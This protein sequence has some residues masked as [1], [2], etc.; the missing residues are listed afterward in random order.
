MGTKITI[1][2][3]QEKNWGEI[4]ITK[5]ETC[6]EEMEN[7]INDN[8]IGIGYREDS[9][10]VDSKND[11]KMNIYNC[12]PYD[13]GVIWGNVEIKYCPFCGKKIKIYIVEMK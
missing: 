3:K 10:M 6:C 5:K 12:K 13:E 9:W 1:E 4:R 8:F 7:T 2:Y 11:I